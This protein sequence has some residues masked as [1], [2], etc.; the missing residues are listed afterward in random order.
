MKS[1]LYITVKEVPYKTRLFNALSESYDLTV[2]YEYESLGARNAKWARSE[3][4]YHKRLYLAEHPSFWGMLKALVRIIWI[5]LKPWDVIVVGCFNT[6]VEMCLM[7][8]L[9]MVHKSYV[10]NL[11]GESYFECRSIKNMIKRFFVKGARAYL[12]AG[13]KSAANLRKV[14]GKTTFIKPYYFSSLDQK[15][16]DE[17]GKSSAKRENFVL[18]IGQYFDYKGMDVALQCARMDTSIQYKFVGMGERLSLFQRKYGCSSLSNVDFIGFMQKKELSEQYEK[19]K[20]FLL[21]SRKECWGLVINEAAS[22]GTPIVSTY[23]S[24]A[25]VEFLSD[26]YPQ[27]LAVPGDAT[28]LLE[29]LKACLEADNIRYGKY[30]K[31][32]SRKYSIEN[33]LRAHVELI[34]T[35]ELK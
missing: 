12:V 24:G 19:C 31:G 16:I 3:E 15:E 25:A 8:F 5:S 18:V 29:C 11:D 33:M 13:E 28:S 1:V 27:Y 2:A 34:N 4:Q 20:C 21:P 9:R 7:L 35:L 22:F 30:L 23:G 10:L 17:N 6:K 26:E 14:V 32:K